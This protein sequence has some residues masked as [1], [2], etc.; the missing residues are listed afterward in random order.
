MMLVVLNLPLIGVR[1]RLLAIPMPTLYAG[2]LVLAAMGT[3][4]A[5]HSAVELAILVAFGFIGFFMRGNGYPVAPAVVGLIPG[6][7]ADAQLRRR[8]QMSLSEPMILLENPGSATVLGIAALAQVVPLI[9]KG[10]NRFQM[11]ED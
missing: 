10:L 5:N 9:L 8:L 4:A 11:Q 3:V 7:T 1:I 6:P 2:I